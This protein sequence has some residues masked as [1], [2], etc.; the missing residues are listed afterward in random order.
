[1]PWATGHWRCLPF[2][3]KVSGSENIVKLETCFNMSECLSFCLL[4][5]K[6]LYS[7]AV[8]FP[9]LKNRTLVNKMLSQLILL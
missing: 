8:V 9:Y 7:G 4:H 6:V 1:M 3:L 5:F 2:H